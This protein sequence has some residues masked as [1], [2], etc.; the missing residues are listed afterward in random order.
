MYLCVL[1]LTEID[2]HFFPLISQLASTRT[3][4]LSP[5]FTVV[6]IP[7]DSAGDS[8]DV[9]AIAGSVCGAVGFLVIV[10][11]VIV[12]IWKRRCAYIRLIL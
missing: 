4:M 5:S 9:A 1:L 10:V 8:C 11:I 7:E 6:Q 2:I 12:V 3:L